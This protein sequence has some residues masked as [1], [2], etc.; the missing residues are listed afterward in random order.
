MKPFLFVSL[1][2]ATILANA[3]FTKVMDLP[4]N[5]NPPAP[6][7]ANEYNTWNSKLFYL[8]NGSNSSFDLIVTDGTA[9]GTLQVANM[10]KPAD[11]SSWYLASLKKGANGMYIKFSYYDNVTFL[12]ND[13]LWYSD[14][15]AAN[16]YKLVTNARINISGLHNLTSVQNYQRPYQASHVGNIFYFWKG[17]D[18]VYATSLYLW[19]SDGTVAGTQPVAGASGVH[20]PYETGM[21]DEYWDVGLAYNGSYYFLAQDT[22]I[23]TVRA[24]FYKLQVGVPQ[25]LGSYQNAVRMGTVFKN[26]IYFMATQEFVPNSGYFQ[27]EIFQSDGTAA[28]TS[29]FYNFS[30]DNAGN[31]VNEQDHFTFH[32]TANYMFIRT[33]D[34]LLHNI[35]VTDGSTNFINL[36][37]GSV[38]PVTHF[39]VDDQMAYFLRASND[40]NV[41][42]SFAVNMSTLEKT[43][44]TKPFYNTDAGVV[45]NGTLWIAN[46]PTYNTAFYTPWRSVGTDGTTQATTNSFSY[47]TNFF[48]LGTNLYA[49]SSYL[50]VLY[51]A[52][53]RFDDNFTFNNSTGDN[54]WSTPMN[55]VSKMIPLQFDDAVV[56]AAFNPVI[57]AP[58]FANN[59]TLNSPLNFTGGDLNLNG[60]LNLGAPVTLN[61]GSINLKGASSQITNG[62]AANYIVTNSA[63]TVNVHNLNAARGAV[64]LPIGTANHYNPITISNSGTPDNFS[65]RVSEGIA[66]TSNGAVNATW[67]ISEGTAGGSNVNL[68]FGWNAA[69]QNASFIAAGAKVG[70]YYNGQWNQENSGSV[71]GSGPFA[72]TSTGI[73]T[74]SPF[75][76]MNFGALATAEVRNSSVH[77]YPNP[78]SNYLQV[79]TEENGTLTLFDASGKVIDVA[80]VKKGNNKLEM[81][82]MPAGL[83]YYALKNLK[84][85]TIASG[86]LL[87]N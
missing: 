11:A 82:V 29:V 74:F 58:A 85:G 2:L 66:N 60:A 48:R 41:Y 38:Y 15:T 45:R 76:V 62:S 14:G 72:I 43:T 73:T 42:S 70:H 27:R 87:K 75:A 7:A 69:Q 56:P 40:T 37:N 46:K 33:N 12:Q 49:F 59:M 31:G 83:Y 80:M 61:T 23:N 22:G 35:L 39:Y 6:L 47:A 36:Y 67:D 63:G 26:K 28:G 9:A 5:L 34:N 8:K 13:E 79:E 77:V 65:A 25:L 24:K 3:Q 30:G 16:T 81:G 53:Y 68:T 52:L 50:G 57:S 17:A 4:A 54:Q 86:K 18:N 44:I 20:L 71:I 51:N 84:G 78:F 10:P 32:K 1:L 64:S 55:W 21:T 19:Q